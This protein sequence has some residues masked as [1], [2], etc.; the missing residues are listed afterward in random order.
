MPFTDINPLEY[1][2]MHGYKIMNPL[3]RLLSA[4]PQYRTVYGSKDITDLSKDPGGLMLLNSITIDALQ[5][6]KKCTDSKS[7]DLLSID[8]M[9]MRTM[10][11]GQATHE[12]QAYIDAGVPEANLPSESALRK[13]TRK[14]VADRIRD[15]WELCIAARTELAAA[16]PATD[17]WI[18]RG[19]GNR[20]A[21]ALAAAGAAFPDGGLI[22]DTTR[23][24]KTWHTNQFWSTSEGDDLASVAGKAVVW[25][26]RIKAGATQGRAGGLYLSEKEVLFP[27]DMPIFMEGGVSI[28]AADQ[29]AGLK[30]DIF[31]R[32]EEL[33][34]KISSVFA[35]NSWPSGKA[36]FLVGHEE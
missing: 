33:R 2:Y 4:N 6:L 28:S 19:D 9:Q 27:Y 5:Y 23:F 16:E 30:L 35:A 29:I 17:P 11:T 12:R 21:S 1:Y 8:E 24:G 10:L 15:L 25:L 34:S 31:T 18:I 14:A 22:P 3:C 32:P 20:S 7:W 13:G 36:K 26:V